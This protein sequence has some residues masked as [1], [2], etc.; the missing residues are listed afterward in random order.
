MF[1]LEHQVTSRTSEGFLGHLKEN[2]LQSKESLTY[3]TEHP[4]DAVE[5]FAEWLHFNVWLTIK[6]ALLGNNKSV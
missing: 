1:N 2:M 3:M 5:A 4:L 6:A